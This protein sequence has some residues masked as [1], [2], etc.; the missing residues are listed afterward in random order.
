MTIKTTAWIARFAAD[1]NT[2]AGKDVPF[3][4]VTLPINHR[5]ECYY[6]AEALRFTGKDSERAAVYF[7]KWVAVNHHMI[8]KDTGFRAYKSVSIHREWFLLRLLGEALPG[9]VAGFGFWQ[10]RN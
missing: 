6:E 9:T 4:I 7:T 3:E 10:R 5:L 8:Y 1:I 2:A